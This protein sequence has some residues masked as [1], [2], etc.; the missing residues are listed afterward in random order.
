MLHQRPS[1]N[2]MVVQA[3]VISA[4]HVRMVLEVLVVA[5]RVVLVVLLVLMAQ[6]ILVL[7][8]VEAH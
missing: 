3:Q 6:Q 8:V 7:A 1:L 4:Q 2:K 5:V